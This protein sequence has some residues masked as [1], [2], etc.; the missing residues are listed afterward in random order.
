MNER[1]IQLRKDLKLTQQE[2]ADKIGSKRNTVANYE[3]GRSE[4]SAAVFST[5]CRTFHVNESWL[6]DGVG[7]MYAKQDLEKQIESFLGGVP[8]GSF[9]AR[10]V[11]VLASLPESYW[12]VLE[13]MVKEMAG[14]VEGDSWEAEKA[15][16]VREYSDFLD[17]EKRREPPRSGSRGSGEGCGEDEGIA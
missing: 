8:D 10:F 17:E 15:R 6:R 2:F 16:R 13:R 12:G 1:L 5:I 9:K 7:E 14:E 3:L 4:P 11:S